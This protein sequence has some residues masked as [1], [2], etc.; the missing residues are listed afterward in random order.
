MI[1]D[2]MEGWKE[3]IWWILWSVFTLLQ[4]ILAFFLYNPDGLK[5]LFYLGWIILILGF[6]IGSLGVST[7]KKMGGVPKGKSF[8]NTRVFVDS[9]IYSVV[10]HPLY[11]GFIL[12]ILGL[13]LISQ[14]WLSVI[15][16]FTGMVLFYIDLRRGEER[17]NIEKFGA[18][19][20][21]P[22]SY[23]KTGDEKMRN[24]ELPR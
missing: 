19:E 11:L 15:S 5:A 20:V 6:V 8:V 16:G 18:G 22:T 4:V 1:M 13:T 2:K 3:N 21:A 7:L 17:S 14:H 24:R 12:L 23:M 9:G 10:R